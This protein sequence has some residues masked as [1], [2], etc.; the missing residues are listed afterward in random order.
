MVK[1]IRFIKRLFGLWSNDDELR[2]QFKRL[3]AED[4]EA[5]SKIQDSYREKLSNA[6]TKE[7]LLT[8]LW[9]MIDE[10]KGN[11]KKGKGKETLGVKD[12]K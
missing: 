4:Q 11:E 3:S 10:I 6:K 8:L 2:Y 7:E 9:Q 5:V 1:L 12:E